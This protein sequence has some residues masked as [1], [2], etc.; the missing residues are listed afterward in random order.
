MCAPKRVSSA[1]TQRFRVKLWPQFVGL[2]YK[3]RSSRWNYSVALGYCLVLLVS[4]LQVEADVV[5]Y[6]WTVNYL[7]TA[8]DCVEKLVLAINGQFPSPTVYAVEGDTV[9]VKL[10]NLI[11]TEGVVLHWHG[12]LQVRSV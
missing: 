12:I 7:Y 10:T 2:H 3:M 5:K 8:P 1:E 11:P 4:T 6:D 9:E